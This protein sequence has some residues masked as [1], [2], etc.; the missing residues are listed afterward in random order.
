MNLHRLNDKLITVFLLSIPFYTLLNPTNIFPVTLL[1]A[2][3]IFFTIIL[4]SSIMKLKAMRFNCMDLLFIFLYLIVVLGLIGSNFET[5]I[6]H[7]LAFTIVLFFYYFLIRLTIKNSNFVSQQDNFLKLFPLLFA[8]TFFIGVADYVLLFNEIDI[9]SY[10]I[11]AKTGTPVMIGFDSRPKGFFVEPTDLALFMN[12]ITP[13]ALI[14]FYQHKKFKLIFCSSVM[15][16]LD[17]FSQ[18][19]DKLYNLLDDKGT[20]FLTLPNSRSIYRLIEIVLFKLINIPKYYNYVKLNEN[21]DFYRKILNKKNF[22]ISKVNYFSNNI[23]IFDYLKIFPKY[24]STM[25]LFT[26]RKKK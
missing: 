13:F 23:K 25:I 4:S 5:N 8:I 6:N 10:L 26:L 22:S 19:L 24:K 21:E 9:A 2:F 16:Y 20:L 14:F 3:L 7:F 15:E 11:M 17:N 1:I 18:H 12:I